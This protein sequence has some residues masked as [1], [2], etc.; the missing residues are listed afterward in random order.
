MDTAL[1]QLAYKESVWAVKEIDL[2]EEQR[3]L[4][5]RIGTSNMSDVQLADAQPSL[6]GI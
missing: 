1:K 2:A 3:K 4:Q 5:L 6:N